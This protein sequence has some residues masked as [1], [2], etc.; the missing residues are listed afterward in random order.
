LEAE[1]V[2]LAELAKQAREFIEKRLTTLQ[3]LQI[4]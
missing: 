2:N 1:D 3:A 4:V